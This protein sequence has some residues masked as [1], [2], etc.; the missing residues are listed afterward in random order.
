LG[1]NLPEKAEVL[2]AGAGGGKELV[3]FGEDGA[4]LS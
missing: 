2:I 3:T 4:E 1:K